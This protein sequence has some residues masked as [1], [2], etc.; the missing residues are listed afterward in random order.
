MGKKIEI[1]QENCIATTHPAI[2]AQWHPTL[3]DGLTPM[4]VRAGSTDRVWWICAKGHEW[5]TEVRVRCLRNNGC[6]CCNGRYVATGETDVESQFPELAKEWDFA[7]NGDYTPDKASIHSPRKVGWICAR[8]HK[9]TASIEK[10]T[11]RNQGCP[12]CSGRRAIPGE[13]D[14][15][16]LNPEV[17]LLWNYEKNNENGVYPT[18]VKP[19]SE[20]LAWWN[21]ENG[22][23]WESK[24][25]NV[26]KGHRCPYCSS[27]K[28]LPGVNDLATVNPELALEWHPTKNK[29][30]KPSDVAPH[31]TKKVWWLGKCGHEWRADVDHR[32]GGRGCPL[33]LGKKALTVDKSI[34]EMIPEIV[35]EWDKEK[36]GENH[37]KNVTWRSNRTCWWKCKKGHSYDMKPNAKVVINKNT[38][39]IRI[40][41][42]PICTG[43]RIVKGVNDFATL[44]PE[45]AEQWDV[46][47][48]GGEVK[49][50]SK[51]S[52]KKVWWKCKKG[53]SWK[54]SVEVRTR[55]LNCPICAGQKILPGYNDLS[56]LKPELAKEWHPTKNKG[57]TPLDITPRSSTKKYWWL[58]PNCGNE[59]RAYAYQRTTTGSGCPKC[60]GK[61][62]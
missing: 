27:Y 4:D 24:I 3:N 60:V 19:N 21:C 45:L 1:T 15:A 2:A 11:Q 22:H 50:L 31:C 10:R 16:T 38:G 35:D 37:P 53:H 12:Y 41:E 42:C 43:K 51:G 25:R 39:E 48:N 55:G 17:L 61:V 8:G 62:R 52:E 6:P 56:T 9:W 30:L 44:Y 14:L 5:K 34:F 29:D 33:C 47:K 26:T 13:T 58:C 36:N 49:A 23:S 20:A 40:V 46:E 7:E 54:A 28:V 59:Y 18:N 57:I 32:T